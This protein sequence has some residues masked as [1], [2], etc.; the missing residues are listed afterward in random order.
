MRKNGRLPLVSM[1][2]DQGGRPPSDV[3][4]VVLAAASHYTT[5][6]FGVQPRQL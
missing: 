4:G 3:P 5:V 6:Q 2:L 1:R